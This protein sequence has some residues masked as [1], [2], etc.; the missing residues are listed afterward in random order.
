MNKKIALSN[1]YNR[2]IAIIIMTIIIILILKINSLFKD[3]LFKQTIY[4]WY[5]Y[6]NKNK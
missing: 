3:L 6:Y 2:D 4:S 5:K 1:Y